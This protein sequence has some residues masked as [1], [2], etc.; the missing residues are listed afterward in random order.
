[1][2]EAE[3]ALAA[4]DLAGQPRGLGADLRTLA[5]RGDALNVWHGQLSIA[6]RQLLLGHA[7][8]AEEIL[9]DVDWRGA[10]ARLV[11]LRE[12]V[13]AELALRRIEPRRAKSALE[14]ARKAATRA[15]IPALAREI[16]HVARALTAPAARL[17]TAGSVQLVDL[18]GVE[19]LSAGKTLVV[20][21]CRRR[22]SQH[23]AVVSLARRPVLFELARALARVW[24]EDV[25][26]SLLIEIV[27]GVRRANASHRARLRVEISRLRAELAG[28]AE[29]AAT[30]TGFLLLPHDGANAVVLAP[31]IEGEGAALVALLSDGAAWS[32]SALALAFGSSQRNV[33]RGLAALE[34]A[35]QVR[36]IGRG[37]SQ[38]WLAPPLGGFTTTLLLPALPL[39][40]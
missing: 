25:S 3:V 37:R 22:I 16:E 14:R 8:D 40:D 34:E 33:Q 20:D 9:R 4:R 5:S 30:N 18:E 1:V 12:L 26:R 15:Q 39:T 27:F 19:R 28:L 38:R 6:R 21:A 10:P 29:I 35:G 32:T 13:A 36:A 2:A 17:L 7:A 24:P 11:A 31:P 23:G